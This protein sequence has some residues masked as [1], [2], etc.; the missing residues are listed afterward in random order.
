MKERLT[1]VGL[2]VGTALTLGMIW[3]DSAQ[4]FSIG[5]RVTVENYLIDATTGK[6]NVFQGPIPVEVIAGQEPDLF[7]F[8][9]IWDIDLIADLTKPSTSSILFDL[10]SIFGNVESGHDVYS[11]VGQ[12]AIKSIELTTL[13][14]STFLIPPTINRLGSNGFEVIFSQGFAFPIPDPSIPP[15]P[16]A[17]NLTDPDTD[18]GVRI[19]LV[20][21]PAPVP[22]P[23]LLPGLVGMGLAAWRR[24]R[25]G[26]QNT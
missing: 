24:R 10:N 6:E 2:A 8:G 26:D 3:A 21:E 1:G 4:A 5:S 11:F 25:S 23:A 20:L 15:N 22:T 17:P 16:E 9:G 13:G 14:S 7:Q 19:S 12:R 18:L